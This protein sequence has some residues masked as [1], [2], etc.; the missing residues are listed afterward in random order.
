MTKGTVIRLFRGCPK[1]SGWFGCFFE[2]KHSHSTMKVTGMVQNLG[3]QTL[4]E[5]MELELE[6]RPDPQYENVVVSGHVITSSRTSIIA[7][8]SSENFKGIGY[9]KAMKLYDLFGDDVL[10]IIENSPD[11][12]TANGFT[13]REAAI[14]TAGVANQALGN[15]LQKILY[16]LSQ[17]DFKRIADFY[18]GKLMSSGDIQ[19]VVCR[20]KANPYT[21]FY[22]MR[23]DMGLAFARKLFASLDDYALRSSMAETDNR[24]IDA[25]VDL[26]TRELIDRT[27]GAF[28][29]LT[30]PKTK[31]DFDLLLDQLLK[32][33][34]GNRTAFNRAIPA[35]VTPK[36]VEYQG[37]KCLYDPTM[38]EAELTC[39][40][41]LN[42]L[43]SAKPRCRL[44]PKQI[45]GYIYEYE[46]QHKCTLDT[47]QKNA[48]RDS[49][50]SGVSV[51]TGGPGRGKTTVINCIVFVWK[52]QSEKEV[53]LSAPTGAAAKRMYAAVTEGRQWKPRT[54]AYRLLRKP[55]QPGCLCVIDET[56]ML[57]LRDAAH[58]L[59]HF[60][61]CQVIFVGDADQLPSVENGQFLK[62]LCT[63]GKI[64]VSRLVTC[65]RTAPGSAAILD[66]AEHINNGDP[67]SS[68]QTA[69]GCFTLDMVSKNGGIITD[70]EAMGRAARAYL[71][72]HAS[73]VPLSRMCLI[74]PMRET[75][76]LLN[77]VLRETLNPVA[78]KAKYRTVGTLAGQ[79]NVWNTNGHPIPEADPKTK[80]PLNM[81][82]G[83][84]IV[85]TKNLS[86]YD[87]VNGDT[88]TIVDYRVPESYSLSGGKDGSKPY[89]TFRTDQG[90]TVYLDQDHFPD[91]Q[92]AYAVTIH[93]A[94]GCEY[95]HVMIVLPHRLSTAALVNNGF[96]CRNLLYT[97]VTRAKLSVDLFG[98]EMAIAAL[99]R[100]AMHPRPSLLP[101]R[102]D[103]PA[104]VSQ[105]QGFDFSLYN[106]VIDL[107]PVIED[108]TM[109]DD[110]QYYNQN[111]D[112]GME[113][114]F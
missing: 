100:N 70:Q 79:E 2:P 51:I 59:K 104:L 16:G 56:S 23:L 64:T 114:S 15:Q 111:G 62:D 28:I 1:P 5:G 18:R 20:I 58:S 6:L 80:F 13:D 25:A 71:D 47:Y 63:S 112:Y 31:Q 30:D 66:N 40:S 77:D 14:L 113:D 108:E 10:D 42:K 39:A 90:Q 95:D 3:I 37:R 78:V 29:E 41:I 27:N 94:Q 7:Y 84:R 36:L 65:Y 46:L 88:G 105:T 11:K 107:E 53:V 8:L 69:P 109:G 17:G 21:L 101:Q 45:D 48:V 87:L 83:D 99:M 72:R 43:Q 35:Q 106:Q 38:L 26:A 24:R 110:D 32:V 67:V 91:T 93:K 22:D 96:S 12:L 19:K 61:D 33:N 86:V 76:K 44:S 57:C 81:R 89:I 92:L 97:A 75:V 49:L 68:M 50:L 60:Q 102:L 74:S 34:D 73:G 4:E 55:P 9:K 85:I 52:K 82:V 98:S 103:T 54:I